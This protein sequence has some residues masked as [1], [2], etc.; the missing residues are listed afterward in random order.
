[1]EQLHQEILS[2]VNQTIHDVR[3]N[4]EDIKELWK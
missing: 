4:C 1:M 3:A 2:I